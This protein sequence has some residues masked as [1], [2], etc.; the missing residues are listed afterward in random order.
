M[1]AYPSLKVGGHSLPDPA[2][3]LPIGVDYHWSSLPQTGLVTTYIHGLLTLQYSCAPPEFSWGRSSGRPVGRRL[4]PLSGGARAR[5]CSGLW[6]SGAA[7]ASVELAT[8]VDFLRLLYS[9]IRYRVNGL[10][11]HPTR[12]GRRE[13]RSKAHRSPSGRAAPSKSNSKAAAGAAAV[14]LAIVRADVGHRDMALFLGGAIIRIPRMQACLTIV[15][16]TLN[17]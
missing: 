8:L 13:S 9:L 3:Q 1:H 14:T 7:P 4:R 17:S 12:A 6:S 2:V 10:P 15:R 11:N 5:P 16:R